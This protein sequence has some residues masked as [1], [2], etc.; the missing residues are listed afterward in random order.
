MNF[1]KSLYTK[2]AIK[3]WIVPYIG[4]PYYSYYIE[5]NLCTCMH[6]VDQVLYNNYDMFDSTH[7]TPLMDIDMT[8]RIW[9]G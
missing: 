8:E 2:Q 1:L 6:N 5:C 4:I 7:I 3:V 9:L